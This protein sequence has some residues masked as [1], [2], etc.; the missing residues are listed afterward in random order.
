MA[1][2]HLGLVSHSDDPQDSLNNPD[3]MKLKKQQDRSDAKKIVN[4][5]R[6]MGKL[7]E[8]DD[9]MDSF[10]D[11]KIEHQA[12]MTSQIK[13]TIKSLGVKKNNSQNKIILESDE[14]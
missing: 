4:P 13:S 10:L 9:F 2:N 5:L 14:I 6:G 1:V 12:R 8:Y 3:G 11:R 7:T